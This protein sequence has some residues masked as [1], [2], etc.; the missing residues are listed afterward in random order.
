MGWISGA[1]SVA[2]TAIKAYSDYKQGQDAKDVYQ[3]NEAIAKYQANYIKAASEKEVEALGRSVKDYVARQRA[4]QGK[5]GTVVDE[6]SNRGAVIRSYR[7]ADIDAALIRWRANQEYD[8]AMQGANLLGTQAS[9]FSS[10]GYLNAA[11]T[12]LGGLSKWDW[13]T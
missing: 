4:I 12:I 13:K 11:T 8:L 6:G 10:A 9:Q 5:S 3:Y 1:L 7:E 2:G